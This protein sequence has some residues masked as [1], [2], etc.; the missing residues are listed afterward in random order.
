[1]NYDLIIKILFAVVQIVLLVIHLLTP[2]KLP[3][4]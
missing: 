3:T 1:M 4:V 2:T